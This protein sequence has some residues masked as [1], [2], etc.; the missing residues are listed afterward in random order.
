MKL[1]QY[2]TIVCERL[3]A[4]EPEHLSNHVVKVQELPGTLFL[5]PHSFNGVDY[6]TGSPAI[7][8]DIL[9]DFAQ[10]LA[11]EAIACLQA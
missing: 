2:C 10:L 4:H 11:A 9:K 8:D 5:T 3:G 7:R 1:G 6:L